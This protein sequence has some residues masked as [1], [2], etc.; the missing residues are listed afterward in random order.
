MNSDVNFRIVEQEQVIITD[1]LYE[2]I[3]ADYVSSDLTVRQIREKYNL[4]HLDWK[5]LS[6]QFRDELGVKMR[7]RQGAKH[8][9]K[10]C[11]GYEIY[12]LVDGKVRYFGCVRCDEGTVQRIVELCKK[13]GWNVDECKR[14]INWNW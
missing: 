14:I 7:P 1:D 10:T 2:K 5:H 3:K 8:Y 9:Y 13:V 12:K 4:T 6:K 11:K